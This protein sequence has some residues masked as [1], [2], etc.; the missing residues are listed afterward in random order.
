MSD[1][2]LASVT[3]ISSPRVRDYLRWS[4]KNARL[5]R[6]PGTPER[7]AFLAKKMRE[8]VK[9]Q[10]KARTANQRTNL[11]PQMGQVIHVDFA[12]KKRI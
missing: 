12:N 2:E 6:T 7:E 1:D 10:A 3:D 4:I 9:Q 8:A 5:E 11:S